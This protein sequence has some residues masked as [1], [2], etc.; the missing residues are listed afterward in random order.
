MKLQ[1]DRSGKRSIRSGGDGDRRWRIVGGSLCRDRKSRPGSGA[2]YRA[3]RLD[4]PIGRWLIPCRFLLL[5][6]NCIRLHNL[7]TI[8]TLRLQG[9]QRWFSGREGMGCRAIR[10]F[11]FSPLGAGM[12]AGLAT[13]ARVG[14]RWGGCSSGGHSVRVFLSFFLPKTKINNGSFLIFSLNSR[15]YIDSSR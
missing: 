4:H 15:R 12:S 8:R 13:E 6:R 7:L 1:T 10:Q 9:R 14:T 5:H 3:N 2:H 11:G